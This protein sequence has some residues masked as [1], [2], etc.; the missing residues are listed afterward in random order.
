TKDFN[1]NLD[2]LE[3][4]HAVNGFDAHY[5][6][7]HADMSNSSFKAAI[8]V[9]SDGQ[10]TPER[11][12]REMLPLFQTYRDPEG[13][14][15]LSDKAVLQPYDL[16]K[17]NFH[18]KL[19]LQKE[20][21]AGTNFYTDGVVR[22]ALTQPQEA[23]GH[24]LYAR[25]FPEVVTHNAGRW[26]KKKPIPNT[27]YTPLVKSITVD[28]TL[29]QAEI[30]KLDKVH[31]G[32]DMQLFH[33]YPYGHRQG[34][35]STN[36]NNFSLL[37][38]FEDK[39]SLYIGLKGL[40]PQ[41][42][43]SLFFE[44]EEK[45]S[46]NTTVKLQEL[47]WSYLYNDQWQP[48]DSLHILS[49]TTQQ[50]INSG[51]VKL[52]AP[53]EACYGNTRLDADL[54]WIRLSAPMA[55]TI[56]PMVK[57]IFTNA[58]LAVRD[59]EDTAG[60]TMLAPM[61]IKSLQQEIKG[62]MQVWQLFPSFGGRPAET[63]MQYYTRVSERLRHKKRPVTNIDLIQLI[64]EAFPEILIVKCINNRGENEE[65]A[66][67]DANLRLVVVPRQP[68]DGLYASN[69]PRASMAT[70]YRIKEYAEG[71]LSSFAHVT[72]H[73]PVYEKVKI[74]CHVC[75]SKKNNGADNNYYLTRLQEDIRRYLT[76]WLFDTTSDVEIGST[77][78]LSE[79]MDFIKRLPYVEYVT[80]FSML[81]FFKE[82]DNRGELLHCMLDTAVSNTGYVKSSTPEAVLIPAP[83]HAIRVLD[84]WQY[85]DP[86]PS[87]VGQVMTGEELI[88]G[89][90]HRT[91]YR[92]DADQHNPEGEIISLTIQPR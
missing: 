8:S 32:N 62:I 81:H 39:A 50:F 89:Q 87:G 90:Q 6:D 35:P 7:Y 47:K 54:Q 60:A 77:L 43:L 80:A 59:Q 27:P 92:D 14:I 5:A 78:Y 44:L 12:R 49:D 67:P 30:F 76:P 38:Q 3:L 64:L 16:Q 1:I 51:I 65:Y 79:I 52:R 68:E 18:N 2:W 34:Y 4:P 85:S 91:S 29:E 37:P 84:E 55:M 19:L 28:Y 33:M 22:L 9:F 57:G 25:L 11:G 75:F 13:R 56:R 40:Q 41:E 46:H 24:R 53:A 15:F 26:T 86:Q 58:G 23:F 71:L 61:S 45:D 20:M 66:Q 17:L 10:F 83:F 72:V 48:F 21:E 63:T 73:N 31:N 70:L 69:E 74:C 82:R 88:I 36:Q 42:E